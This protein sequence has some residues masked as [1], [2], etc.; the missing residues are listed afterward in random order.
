[1]IKRL[2]FDLETT[3]VH[4]WVH[5]IHQIAGCIE[6]DGE[7]VEEFNWNMKPDPR[8]KIELEALAI[9]GVTMEDLEGYPPGSFIYKLF[10]D[11]LAKYVNKFDKKDKFFLVGFNSAAFDMPFLRAWFKQNNDNYFGSWFWPNPIDTY[12]LASQKL[13]DIRP[14]MENF[15]LAT[16]CRQ[17]GIE[18][19]DQ[20]LHDANYDIFLTRELYK[21][22][23]KQP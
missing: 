21:A 2:F 20:L 9:A 14:T 16:A 13:M 3:G 8:A 19:D 22:V 1:M 10:T 23:T 11:M 5:G 18:V 15:K 4:F 6:I 17:V 12:V 7:V